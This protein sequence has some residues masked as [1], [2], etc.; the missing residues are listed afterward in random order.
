MRHHPRAAVVWLALLLSA[1]LAFGQ[2]IPAPEKYFG[3]QVGAEKKLVR[4]D[5]I[6]EYMQA[7]ARSSDRVRFQ[8]LGKTTNNNPFVLMVISSPDNL[9]KLEHYRAI[10]KRLFDPRTIAS[11]D[12]AKRLV[13]EGRI[14]VLVTCSIHATEI[15]ASQM[16]IE[17]VYRL[18]TEKSPQ[19]QA[20]LD[21]VVFLLVPSL[22]PDG[23]IIVTD[24]YNK[25]LG[26]PN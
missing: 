3:H 12:E 15:G 1:A 25:T 26:T 6:V 7:A 4:W 16:S 11:D 19:I 17:A 13:Q 22:N 21:N 24:W 2:E 8:E 20:I 10:N 23:Q 18:A 9:K 5:K 14:F